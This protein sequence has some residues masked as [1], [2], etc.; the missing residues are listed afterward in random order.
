M[1]KIWVSSNPVQVFHTALEVV[2]D[3]LH[4]LIEDPYGPRIGVQYRLPQS[5]DYHKVHNPLKIVQEC[6]C[7]IQCLSLLE[8]LS[9]KAASWRLSFWQT[10]S[11]ALNMLKHSLQIG[12]MR[13]KLCLQAELNLDHDMYEA[14]FKDFLHAVRTGDNSNIRSLYHDAVRTYETSR[15]ITDASNKHFKAWLLLLF[16]NSLPNQSLDV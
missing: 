4:V 13:A 1:Q 11:R 6:I 10:E 3:G 14:Q 2:C 8:W 12:C 9:S 5:N 16:G 7:R 15:W